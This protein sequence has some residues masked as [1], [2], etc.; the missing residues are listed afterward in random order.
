MVKT[1]IAIFFCVAFVGAVQPSD[2][3]LTSQQQ[4][5][6][7]I[8]SENAYGY[9]A[10]D[11]ELMGEGRQLR[12]KAHYEHKEARQAR[13][14]QKHLAKAERAKSYRRQQKQLYKANKHAAKADY[15]ATM[16]ASKAAELQAS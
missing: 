2:N 13:R 3:S 9:E 5:P 1:T 11:N 6:S 8:E 16:R 12:S 4:L 10:P 15:A 7:N 14:S